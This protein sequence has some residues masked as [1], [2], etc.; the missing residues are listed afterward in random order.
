MLFYLTS[1]A[2]G[3]GR[4]SRIKNTLRKL[5]GVR[6]VGV[7]GITHI[8]YVTARI[9]PDD[10]YF[11]GLPCKVADIEIFLFLLKNGARP[12]VQ[13]HVIAAEGFILLNNYFVT[14]VVGNN[15]VNGFLT[16]K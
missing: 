5:D 11:V 8:N 7:I 2:L 3:L 9:V 1:N 12:F 15:A 14:A 6:R 16:E 4:I 13:S 10:A